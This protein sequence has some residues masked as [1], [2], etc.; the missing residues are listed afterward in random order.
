MRKLSLLCTLLFGLPVAP[1]RAADQDV[2]AAADLARIFRS[3]LLPNLPDP[4]VSQDYNW[5]HQQMTTIG[6]KW[7]KEGLLAKPVPIKSL[8]N[9]G[10]WRK[11]SL[12][13][14]NP[15]QALE[16][17]VKDVQVP[18]TGRMTFSM[19]LVLP[20]HAKFEQQIWRTGTR[21]Y[22]GETRARC[23]VALQLQCESTSRIDKK[24]GSFLPDVVLRLRVAEAKL[25]YFDFVVEHTAGVGGEAAKVLGEAIHDTI[26]KVKP[27][28]E[29]NL[30]DKANAAIVKAGDTKEVHLEFSKLFDKK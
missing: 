3:L 11:I 14:D 6:V 25:S 20:I 24:P 15:D 17:S 1:V 27:S 2:P 23:K 5:G 13:A 8:R 16:I 26:K 10:K 4:L 12:T 19:V 18:E 30:L 29:R 7:E 21:F 28:L 9:D 22:S